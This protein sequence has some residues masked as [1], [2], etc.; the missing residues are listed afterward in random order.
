MNKVCLDCLNI[1]CEIIDVSDSSLQCC[2]LKRKNLTPQLGNEPGTSQLSFEC[3]THWATRKSMLLPQGI[4]LM[5][6][7][8]LCHQPILKYP[9]TS[10]LYILF[11]E[12][13][14][15][16]GQEYSLN[17]MNKLMSQIHWL[18]RNGL[19]KLYIIPLLMWVVFLEKATQLGCT[20]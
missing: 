8:A 4:F 19:L 16:D 20:N 7:E 12:Q 18:L 1:N 5:L 11:T 9:D 13:T 14:S 17:H 6:K 10:K 3:S 15:M 2:L